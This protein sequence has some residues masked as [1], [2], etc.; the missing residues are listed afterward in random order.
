MDGREAVSKTV[1]AL[2]VLLGAGVT[3]PAQVAV[4]PEMF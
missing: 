4:V 2:L 3:V 1:A